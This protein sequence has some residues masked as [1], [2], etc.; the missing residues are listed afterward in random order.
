[1]AVGPVVGGINGMTQDGDQVFIS[2]WAC[3]EGRIESI[4]LQVLAD[5]S[6]YDDV[7][8]TILTTGR[9]NLE[10]EPA[11]NQTCRDGAGG[12]HRF[13]I[14]L[15]AEVFAKDRNRKVFVHGLRVVN[16]VPNAAIE[17]SGKPFRQLP[18]LTLQYPPL[19]AFPPLAGGYR[20]S[21]EHPRVFTT[22][23]ELKEMAARI[24][25]PGSYSMRRFGLLAAQIAKDL[26]TRIDWDGAYA[27]CD[28]DVYLHA[29]SYEPLVGYPGAIRS[30]EQLR[31]AMNTRAGAD[32]PKGAAVVASRL[33]LYAALIKAGA[34]PPAG[35]PSGDQ[36]ATLAKRI[37]IAWGE[38]GFRDQSGQFLRESQYCDAK[39]KPLNPGLHLSRGLVYS[40]YA[41]D[42]LTYLAALDDKEIK[43]LNAFHSNMYDVMRQASTTGFATPQPFCQLYANGQANA[44]AALLSIARLL[45]D[46]RKFDAV[47]RG[48]DSANPVVLS[49]VRY[50]DH[51]IFGEADHPTDCYPNTG[52]DGPRSQ[53]AFTTAEVSPGEVMDR[54]R[55]GNAGQGIGYPMFTLERLMDA[56]EV[57]RISGFDPY[58]YRGRH[59]QSLEM[60]IQYYACFAKGAG[61][62]KTV[63]SE[64]SGSCLNSA[65]YVGKL[66]NEVD[67]LATIGAYRFPENASITNVEAAAKLSASSREPP[68]AILF[69]KWRD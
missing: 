16:G 12:H 36:A 5:H 38:R 68:D 30:E 69:G 22:T 18:L 54:Y 11:V 52:P 31:A 10:S 57:L 39:G 7:K 59:N 14:S 4:G 58:A 23:A 47:V 32:A 66:V 65:Q 42:L 67:Q 41:Q 1:M 55:N 46:A 34:L 56:A 6:A 17:G 27:G 29:F 20:S 21:L 37:L 25:Q 9:A 2:G 50:F 44:L 3:Q 28:M 35:A 51:V 45:N 43:E 60:A 62:G 53:T 24:N 8:G 48:A 19:T 64:N 63:T 15:S 49:W 61:F 13:L 26:G 40:V 33:T